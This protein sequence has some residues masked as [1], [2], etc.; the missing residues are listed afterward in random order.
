VMP[1]GAVVRVGVKGCTMKMGSGSGPQG[2]PI[3]I[4]CPVSYR[5]Y[6]G[7]ANAY[8]LATDD[9]TR[10]A[11]VVNSAAQGCG[12]A[13]YAEGPSFDCAKSA[14]PDEVTICNSDTLS[15]LDRQ[16]VDL[17][18]SVRDGLGSAQQLRLREEQRVWLGH[19]AACQK[20]E[21]CIAD[22]YRSRI[23]QL[24]GSLA[25]LNAPGERGSTSRVPQRCR[26]RTSRRSLSHQNGGRRLPVAAN[27]KTQSRSPKTTNGLSPIHWLS[28]PKMAN[29]L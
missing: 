19:R 26:R 16:M 10:L 22:A 8:Y 15:V 6:D 25:E 5:N 17:F 7:W 9:R 1:N 21:R 23:A 14:A 28:S 18:A 3:N 20:D 24:R 12:S 13:K 29:S 11:C 27:C 4:W 2:A